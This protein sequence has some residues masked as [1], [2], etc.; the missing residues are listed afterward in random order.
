M[1]NLTSKTALRLAVALT[2]LLCVTGCDGPVNTDSTGL[3]QP[4]FYYEV[5]GWG[6]NP[7]IYEFTPK[8]NPDYVCIIAV[9]K[10]KSIFCIPKGS[11]T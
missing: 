4:D 2:V 7:D 10:V 9:E 3:Y 6:T 1:K 5:D 11:D 8:S